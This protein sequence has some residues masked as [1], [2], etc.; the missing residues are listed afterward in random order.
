MSGLP[1]THEPVHTRRPGAQRL[2]RWLDLFLSEELRRA[3]PTLVLRCR[4]LAGAACVLS[5]LN[6]SFLVHL[7][8]VPHPWRFMVAGLVT[9]VASLGTLGVLRRGAS[10][11]PAVVLL[12]ASL[13]APPI[14]LSLFQAN[15]YIATHATVM[16][17]PAIVVYLLGPRR[18]LFISLCIS[19][20]VGAASPLYHTRFAADLELHDKSQYWL[21]HILAGIAIMVGWWLSWLFSTAR[22]KAQAELEQA[23][24]TI[25]LSENRLH[26]LIESTENLVCSINT[27]GRLLTANSALRAWF[28][29]RFGKELLLGQEVLSLV[30][31]ELE[32]RWRQ[33]F[34][35]AF[36]GQRLHFEDE[37]VLEGATFT[38]DIS[39]NP[40]LEEDG[41]VAGV[42]LF[43]QDITARKR[44][45]RQLGE[46]HRSLLDVSR[47]AGMAEIATGVLHNV[48]NA[49]NNL[50]TSASLVADGLQKLRVDGLSKT[51][52]LLREHSADAGF[53]TTDPRG[54][55][56]P[57]YL[58][59]LAEQMA[60][61]RSA[62]LEETKRVADGIEHIGTIIRM[63]RQYAR[64][65]RLVERLSVPQL[66][67]EA[68]RLHLGAFEQL[69]IHLQREYTEVPPVLAD[70]HKLLHVLLHLLS[71]ARQALL[72]VERPDKR[73][74]LRVGLG[75]Q[76]WLRIEVADNGVGIPAENLPLLFSQGFT[77]K[78]SGHGFGLHYSALAV[79]DMK[80]RLTC[81]TPGSGQGAVFVLELP[82]DPDTSSSAS[83]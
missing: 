82:I 2:F 52:S 59:A 4:V 58:T 1:S 7:L 80:G 79:A 9:T 23:L 46:M 3:S 64:S 68:L 12:V 28:L 31:A 63:Q 37:S 61:E 30:P 36:T 6:L 48:G 19:L 66:I 32:E 44:A 57:G 69:G 45:E 10:P 50:T 16:L 41:Q 40:I 71:N 18:G 47:H 78:K 25:Q 15:P 11:W 24:R 54:R 35:Q 33:R 55:K 77:T 73:I 42:T 67:D 34:A 62:L 20:L 83:L 17:I 8:V 74:T 22:D 65:S 75:G 76:G 60:T 5:L 70:P 43:A 29:R 72:E 56:L 49:L 39:L 27:Q 21:L 38:L 81:A 53:L 13:L 51:A 14:F 26:S